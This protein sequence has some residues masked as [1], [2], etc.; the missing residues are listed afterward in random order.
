MVNVT[1]SIPL[2]HWNKA[3]ALNLPWNECLIRGIKELSE[4]PYNK[5]EG[6][7]IVNESW[8]SKAMNIQST[9]QKTIDELNKS[10]EKKQC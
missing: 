7:I 6:E 2:K 10:L 3:K 1:T 5:R 9:M 8:K 4:E